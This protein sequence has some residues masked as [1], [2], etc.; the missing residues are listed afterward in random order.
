M[1][2]SWE[3]H[4]DRLAELGIYMCKQ[5]PREVESSSETIK[6]VRNGTRKRDRISGI[7]G[8]TCHLGAT[9]TIVPG[10]VRSLH[11]RVTPAQC[12]HYIADP[13]SPD[14]SV[15]CSHV[16]RMYGTDQC[17]DLGQKPLRGL[18]R[19]LAVLPFSVSLVG[20]NLTYGIAQTGSCSYKFTQNVLTQVFHFLLYKWT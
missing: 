20:R 14:G 2:Q 15:C 3:G 11:T 6:F 1:T 9:E 7:S 12:T 10:P 19:P 17:S 16:T 5:L 13:L 18:G 8:V 4:G